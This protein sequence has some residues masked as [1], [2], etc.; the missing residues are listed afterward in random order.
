MSNTNPYVQNLIEMGY[1][2]TDCKVSST[3]FQKKTFPC[4][5]YGRQFDTE[6]QYY[7][8]LHEYFNGL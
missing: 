4:V 3:M 1:D 7:A 5:I 2:E 6:E 8:E